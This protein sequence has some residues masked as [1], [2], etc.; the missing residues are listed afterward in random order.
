MI[1]TPARQVAAELGLPSYVFFTSPWMTL[2]HFLHLPELDASRS[3]EHLDAT[4]PICLPGY[5][6]I[7]AHELP[8]WQGP[9]SPIGAA[10]RTLDCWPWPR[11]SAL[12]SILNPVPMIAWPLFAE[13]HI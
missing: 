13:Q 10:S 1:G 2:S 4:E 9:C 11:S 6:P 3:E 7:H 8:R 12:Y 5:A